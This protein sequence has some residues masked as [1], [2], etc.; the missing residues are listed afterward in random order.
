MSA[1]DF[2]R[3]A[4]IAPNNDSG[5]G[6]MAQ[7]MKAILPL[8]RH[9]VCDSSTLPNRPLSGPRESLFPAECSDED[10]EA[11][12]E[13]LKGILFFESHAWHPRLLQTTRRMGV[14]SV[15]V[16]MWE[17]FRGRSPQWENCDFF[18]CPNALCLRVV[19]SYGFTN[20]DCIPWTLDLQ[21]LPARQVCGAARRFVHNGGIMDPD[22]RK[23]TRD[24]LAAFTRISDPTLRLDVRLQKAEAISSQDS[25]IAIHTGN[26]PDPAALYS[27]GDAF[28]QP[29]KLEGMGFSVLEAVASGLPVITLDAPPMNEWVRQPQLLA[30]A[31][32]FRYPA[33]SS[34]WIEHSH[35]R[36]PRAAS[37][38][39]K[40]EWAA[41]HDLGVI[42]SQNRAWAEDTFDSSHLL[43]C[44]ENTL[45]SI[46]RQTPSS[47]ITTRAEP[48]LPCHSVA[49]RIRRAAESNI[50]RKI[51]YLKSPFP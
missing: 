51:P 34:A 22:D 10:L 16:P 13:G 48:T 30:S 46:L 50:G 39:R 3:W 25:R 24:A 20:S 27:E 17:W 19:R 18:A 42:S 45:A 6:R 35:L 15:C 9:Y 23:G 49:S 7:D 26:L 38:A 40:I 8:G 36:L 31:R 43:A 4:L 1:L 12:L 29:S 21:R 33:Y 11:R 28:I 2:S 32:L 41:A 14:R 47:S 44:W 5:L 37:L